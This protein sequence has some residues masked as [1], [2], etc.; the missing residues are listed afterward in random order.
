ML[1][2]TAGLSGIAFWGSLRS[3][4]LLGVLPACAV[5]TLASTPSFLPEEAQC[6]ALV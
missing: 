2:S 6:S 3:M 5:A 4:A 1:A